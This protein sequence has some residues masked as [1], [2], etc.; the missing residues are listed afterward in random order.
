M[1]S[2]N[3]VINSS[4][5]VAGNPATAADFGIAMA[6]AHLSTA[7]I[8]SGSWGA[9][10]LVREYS[11]LSSMV[12]DGIDVNGAAYSV[13][14]AILSQNPHTNSFKLGRLT[15]SVDLAVKFTP[16]VTAGVN[17]TYVFEAVG[18]NGYDFT[19]TITGTLALDV[20]TRAAVAFNV[21]SGSSL[22]SASYDD[23]TVTVKA[24]TAG[25]YFSVYVD[26]PSYCYAVETQTNSTLTAELNA[27]QAYDKDFYGCAMAT[28]ALT[29][30]EDFA[31]FAE[32]ND[33]LALLTTID[34][35]CLTSATTTNPMYVLKGLG[36]NCSA[37]VYNSKGLAQQAGAAVVGRFLAAGAGQIDMDSKTLVG[38]TA[39]D[40]SETAYAY[41]MANYG[42]VYV[43]IE[44]VDVFKEGR[45]AGG[46]RMWLDIARDLSFFESNLKVD[47]FNVNK[48]AQKV[49]FT[50]KGIALYIGKLRSRIN[51]S[52]INPSTGLGIINGDM[53]IS[54]TWTPVADA[55]TSDKA[56]RIFR[57]I[58][59]SFTLGGGVHKVYV[60]GVVNF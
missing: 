9:T 33:K 59:Y 34:T 43:N 23:N 15:S 41:I 6:I 58:D 40:I 22:L 29:E 52:L 53:P 47:F 36:Y 16:Q 13:A 5:T 51:K 24:K 2:I 19:A 39:E 42:N 50:E 57:T 35:L 31:A 32:A 20:V 55:S 17:K 7:E 26:D 48:L 54:I 11:T 30:L 46:D 25:N 4:I 56:N 49:P 28:H 18:P 21:A 14:Q 60:A 38:V 37:V 45:L 8:A 27:I 10:E 12:A 44:G 3:N 1:I